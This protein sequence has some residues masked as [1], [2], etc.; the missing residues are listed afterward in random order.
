MRKFISILIL[1]FCGSM[2]YAQS[3]DV[4]TKILDSE[5]ATYGQ[6]CYL[7]AVYQKLVGEKA[8]YKDAVSALYKEKQISEQYDVNAKITYEEVAGIFAK[9]MPNF[10]ESLMYKIT[11]GSNRYAYKIFKSDGIIRNADPNDFV[12]GR[13]VLNI[14]TLCMMNYGSEKDCMDMEV[15]E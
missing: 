8:S 4:V 9:M 3:A 15:G 14:L 7:S 1:L 5:N 11:D 6:V 10:N 12:S 13:E 2:I